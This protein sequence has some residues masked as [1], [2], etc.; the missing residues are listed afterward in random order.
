MLCFVNF[1][2]KLPDGRKIKLSDDHVWWNRK[3][4]TWRIRHETSELGALG[5][6][7][8]INASGANMLKEVPDEQA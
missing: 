7:R 4:K 6:T 1:T 5:H 3:T 2:I 8:R